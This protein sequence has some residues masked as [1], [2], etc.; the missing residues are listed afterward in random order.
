[1]SSENNL[2]YTNIGKR[3]KIIYT[4]IYEEIMLN[5]RF[6]LTTQFVR[7]A[8][9]EEHSK[10]GRIFKMRYIVTYL[11]NVFKHIYTTQSDASLDESLINFVTVC[12]G[13]RQSNPSKRARFGI[14]I[15]KLSESR[16]VVIV[17][18]KIYPRKDKLLDL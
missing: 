17:A 11:S 15:Y 8:N 16:M 7:S 14:K 13:Y 5:R 12:T 10:E 18:F 1:M 3:K 4:P 2:K 9:N 6:D